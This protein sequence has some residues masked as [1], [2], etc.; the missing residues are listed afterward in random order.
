[1]NL[2]LNLVFPDPQHVIIQSRR[3]S[4]RPIDFVSPLSE[5]NL[6]DIRWY[7]EVYSSQYMMDIDDD[8]AEQ[9]K[10]LL[11]R[12]GSALFTAALGQ[13]EAQAAFMD[14]YSQKQPGRVLTIGASH[15]DILGLPWELLHIPGGGFLFNSNP[16]ISIRRQFNVSGGF[17]L[18]GVSAKG[19]DTHSVYY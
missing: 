16:R 9:I 7:L 13:F 8:R 17:R 11:S 15:P 14:L 12:W 3:G 5:Q 10:K 6:K 1:M 18:N 2:E 4:T 19:K